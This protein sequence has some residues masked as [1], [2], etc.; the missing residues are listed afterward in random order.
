MKKMSKVLACILTIM[1]LAAFSAFTAF[2]VE[3][4]AG[5][6]VTVSLTVPAVFGINGNLS[7]SNPSM[8]TSVNYENKSSATGEISEEK[9]Y[10]FGSEETDITI[11]VTVTVRSDAQP[12][13]SCVITLNYESSDLDG[14]MAPWTSVAQTVTIKA[15]EEQ[16]EPPVEPEPPVVPE[17]PVE[18]EPPVV[19]EPPVPV[20]ADPAIII[21][22]VSAFSA[23]GAFVIGKRR[24]SK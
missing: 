1:I 9:V 14:T 12:G 4:E 10:L 20:T 23:A 11:D 24:K 3:T 21:A 22:A 8:F 17:P 2:A 7:L 19:P 16:P 18:P 6:T 5:Q 13:D 15:T